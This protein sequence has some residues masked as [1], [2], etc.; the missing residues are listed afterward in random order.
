MTAPRIR[1]DLPN[2]CDPPH[3]IGACPDCASA[4]R[5]TDGRLRRCWIC[6]VANDNP[7]PEN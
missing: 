2:F 4:R 3:A 5:L 6:G 1:H 7:N